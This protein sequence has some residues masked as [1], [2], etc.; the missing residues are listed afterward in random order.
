MK[1]ALRAVLVVVL[2]LLAARIG[3][4]LWG[5]SK[6]ASQ[7][8]RFA[9]AVAEAKGRAAARRSP[10][11]RGEAKECDAAQV[12][13]RLMAGLA[14]EATRTALRVAVAEP[15]KPLPPDVRA[16]LDGKSVAELAE[17]V[18]CT[19]ADFRVP[20][21]QGAQM[22]FPD[23]AGAIALANLVVL[24]ARGAARAGDAKRA[25]ERGLDGARFGA[26]F[27]GGGPLIM[28]M[29][30]SVII[31]ASLKELI[32]IY[33]ADAS[34]AFPLAQVAAELRTLEPALPSAAEG[35]HHERLFFLSLAGSYDGKETMFGGLGGAL[36][37]ERAILAHAVDEF[38]ALTPLRM[39]IAAAAERA[40]R[41][42]LSMELLA[43]AEKSWNPLVRIA[44]PDESRYPARLAARLA[45]VR[46]L[47]GG[48]LVEA[49]RDPGGAYPAEVKG[50]PID[51][52][53]PPAPLRYA[54]SA[55]GYKLW[56]VGENGTDEGGAPGK[57]QDDGDVVLARD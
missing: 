24:D 1:R 44:L 54:R 8:Q 9:Q 12:Y 52:C 7:A 16:L 55:A 23:S 57:G 48:A 17:A 40:E 29:V 38:D 36:L 42:R 49:R 37:P 15:D 25:A 5:R 26:D 27:A 45:R 41:K 34:R 14:A 43:R 28:H 35:M 11:L 18:R 33:A 20:F 19:R 31:D 39:K 51:P 56:S 30:G 21:E 10:V 3:A 53:A 32:R 2:A 6:L 4:E 22:R 46:L 50:L 47:Q 13:Q